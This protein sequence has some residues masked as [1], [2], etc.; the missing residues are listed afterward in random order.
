MSLPDE[1]FHAAERHARR[2]SRSRSRLDADA[3]AE[4]LTRHAPDEVTEA[5]DRVVDRIGATATDEFVA[6]EAEHARALEMIEVAQGEVWWAELPEPVGAGLRRPVVVVQGNPLNRSRI[7]TVACVPLTSNL[8]WADAPGKTALPATVTGLAERFGRKHVADHR[9]R[10]AHAR[11][12]RPQDRGQAVSAHHARNRHRSRPLS[13]AAA[14][15]AWTGM[16]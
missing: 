3:I 13:P 1:L 2:S 15:P 12:A 5:M 7:S 14:E 8:A 11:G 16:V 10:P 9:A 6:R 4:Y